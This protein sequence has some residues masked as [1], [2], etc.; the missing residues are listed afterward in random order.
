MSKIPIHKISEKFGGQIAKLKYISKD[1]NNPD[2]DYAHRDDYYIFFFMEKGN[3]TL[4]ID[5]EE[6][7]V[8][9]DT[10]YY[11]LPEQVHLLTGHSIDA[12]AW[13]LIVDS[14]FVKDEYNEI[15][16]KSSLF[17]NRIGLDK[18]IISDLLGCISILERRL[19]FENQSIGL[20]VLYDLISS[21][22]GIIAEVYQ[23]DFP[24]QVNKRPADITFQFKSL[25]SANYQSLKSPS[26]YADKLN[27]S[28][29]YLNEAVK[30]TTGLTVSECIRN[31]IIIRA[32]RL[33]FHTNMSIKEI[34]SELGYDD[35]AYFTRLFSQSALLSPTQ[36]REKHL[37]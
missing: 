2:I 30:T 26:Q 28:S 5:F 25:L 15:L 6:Y 14:S 35:S 21:Y 3:A 4:L 11:I 20:N 13:I 32:K 33:L 23:K 8:T 10:V 18:A 31:E 19:S 12:S 1:S 29:I 9:E 37:K 16:K 22:I 36:F 24:I 7:E 17:K 34:A 27:I